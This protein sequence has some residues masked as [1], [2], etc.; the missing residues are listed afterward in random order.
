M[1]A[2]KPNETRSQYMAR[3]V[4]YVMG[5]SGTSGPAHATAKC[6][7]MWKQHLKH[8]QVMNAR[9]RN[10]LRMDPTRTTLLRKRFIKEIT[11]GFNL[12]KQEIVKLIEKE[13]AF[14]LRQRNHNPSGLV[15]HQ[16]YVALTTTQ[17]LNAFK[18]WLQTQVNQG[19]L[20]GVDTG[21]K[22]WLE[23]YIRDAYEKGSGRSFDDYMTKYKDFYGKPSDFYQGTKEEF[24][25]SSFR[26]PASVERVS[27]MA[28]RAYT[29]LK[30][31]TDAMSTQMNRIMTEAIIQGKSPRDLAREL[32]RAVEGIGKRRAE[33]IARTE[34]IRAHADGQ[35]EA[36]KNL[37]V[38]D[39]GVMVEWS[40]AGDNMVC[41]LCS[42]LDGT[43]IKIKDATSLIPRH[44]NCR[45]AW[46]PANIGEDI[47]GQK[48]GKDAEKAIE[49]SIKSEIPKKYA[50]TR[51]VAE[52][53]ALSRWKGADKEKLG[54]PL[55]SPLYEKSIQPKKT[56]EKPAVPI[57]KVKVPKAAPP[58]PKVTVADFQSLSLEEQLKHPL[59][60]DLRKK[61]LED[62]AQT[63]ERLQSLVST[64]TGLAENVRIETNRYL[65][66]G[67]EIKKA[68]NLPRE[69]Y[70]K[71]VGRLMDLQKEVGKLVDKYAE[72]MDAI[73]IEIDSL[74]TSG[75]RAVEKS[76]SLPKKEQCK[77]KGSLGKT[78]LD[79]KAEN[80]SYKY[81][82]GGKERSLEHGKEVDEFFT[83]L[84]SNKN[85]LKTFDYVRHTMEEGE[86]AF[87]KTSDVFGSYSSGIYVEKG[88]RAKTVAHEVGHEMEVRLKD[89]HVLAQKFR[90]M[91][92]ARAGTSD[93]KLLDVFP[94]SGYSS[95]EI[96]NKDDFEKLFGKDSPS[97]YYAG[98]N[99]NDP[100]ASEI[101]S[102]GVQELY[103]D[104]VNFAK[105]D[106]E[107]F[108][109]IVGL[110]RGVL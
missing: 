40:T 12:L 53:R 74:S 91:R 2:V 42:S 104:P 20:K 21:A 48:R 18:Q 60:E 28:S 63:A 97:A 61:F 49:D 109:F 110:L 66:I 38:T 52:Q 1:P 96:G 68:A 62:T 64:R 98:K 85:G 4:S 95:N 58:L 89:G 22:N 103:S 16:R 44:P 55:K 14:G 3:C 57:P 59:L 88:V 17:Q 19:I 79:Y 65:Q 87:C 9:Q 50:D 32:N 24:L 92:V 8:K 67:E 71:E 37:G 43:V 83:A 15:T 94:E 46:M 26:R 23:Q 39:V 36:L 31:V 25:R 30:G 78:K 102:M 80:G 7:G 54:R 99:Y 108:N 34:T 101:V 81:T 76:L 84:T 11:T 13:D 45:C 70:L 75:K 73:R 27:L 90:E 6:A 82:L 41:E 56:T 105:K 33:T 29:D 72:K 107:Y 51:T 77:V 106:P 35:L 69:Q 93:V 100:K 86:R 10:T 47:A 5:E